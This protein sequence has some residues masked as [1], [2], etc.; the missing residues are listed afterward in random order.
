LKK[1]LL[2]IDKVLRSVY[3]KTCHWLT[4]T[5]LILS[6]RHADILHHQ[7]AIS[8][9]CRSFHE[10]FFST[11]LDVSKL[12]ICTLVAHF[13]KFLSRWKIFS[14]NF[15]RSLRESTCLNFHSLFRLTSESSLRVFNYQAPR[16]MHSHR[17]VLHRM[18]F[19]LTLRRKK[20][21]IRLLFSYYRNKIRIT[22]C[23][24]T[25]IHSPP[26]EVMRKLSKEYTIIAPSWMVASMAC[27]CPSRLSWPAN[28]SGLK[29]QKL[30]E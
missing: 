4:I 5:T 6:Y 2:L 12:I 11:Y 8:K 30:L 28:A 21:Y 23:V 14:A 27:P 22:R 20:S 19:A 9:G 29:T 10:E 7:T 24:F 13:N 16:I 3:Y 17:N 26:I 25:C 15:S 1:E 18:R